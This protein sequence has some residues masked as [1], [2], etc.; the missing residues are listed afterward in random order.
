MINRY[1]HLAGIRQHITPHMFRHSFAT[2]L[3]EQNVDIRYI[4]TMLGHSS[5]NVTEIYTH[6]TMT[7]QK[8]ILIKCKKI[9]IYETGELFNKIEFDIENIVSYY[10][11]CM[12][13]ILMIVVNL[14]ISV[15]FILNISKSLAG[16]T[17]IT[18]PMLYFINFIFQKKVYMMNQKIRIFTDKYYSFLNESLS[19][20]IQIKAFGLENIVSQRYKEYLK[21]REN[22]SK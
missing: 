19:E 13:S 3:L 4:Q 15:Y 17:F 6:V 16:I 5:I 18:I 20:V 21:E 11:D 7:K 22:M 8:D 1:C 14:G 2:L 10:L 9:D 12:T